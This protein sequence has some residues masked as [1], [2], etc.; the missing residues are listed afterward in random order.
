[1][2]TK[3]ALNGMEFVAHHG[4]FEE[5][6]II[7]T[8]FKVD[9]SF[10]FDAQEAAQNDD[11]TKTVNYQEV[12]AIVRREM[13]ISAHIIENVAYRILTGLIKEFPNISQPEVTVYKLNPA[14][15]GKT[16][17]SAVTLNGEQ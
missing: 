12:Y 14:L 6:R 17:W 13:R 10:Y 1:M 4:C 15:G 5:E 3:I 16:A 11:L 7:G 9:V 2:K 8:K